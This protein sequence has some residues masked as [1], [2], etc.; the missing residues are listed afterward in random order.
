MKISQ[1]IHTFQESKNLSVL[2]KEIN[3]RLVQ[4]RELFVLIVTSGIVAAAAIKHISATVSA[5]VCRNA[6]LIRKRVNRDMERRFFATYRSAVC[7]LLILLRTKLHKL[8]GNRLQI[9]ISINRPLLYQ[10]I[11]I[12]QSNWDALNEILL[13]FPKSAIAV[14][15]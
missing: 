5:F 13:A 1:L 10:L 15:S 9:R 11:Q 4:P 3:H 6:F 12:A 2:F 7:K 14:C 8:M